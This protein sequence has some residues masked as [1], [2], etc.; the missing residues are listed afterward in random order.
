MW[1]QLANATLGIWLLAAPAVLG[2]GD[3]AR[4]SDRIV[5]PVAASLAAIAL[6]EVTRP[7]GRANLALALWLLVAP[8]LLGYPVV[9]TVNS[10]LVALM[11]GALSLVP[12]TYRPGRFG[13]GWSAVWR[14]GAARQH[15]AG[16]AEE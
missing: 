7:V 9:A 6:W 16:A 15:G 12:W 13:G 4:T 14:P 1:A 11:L 5:G 3:P 8:W 10:T 2:Y